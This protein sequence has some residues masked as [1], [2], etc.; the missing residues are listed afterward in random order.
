[1]PIHAPAP[2]ILV[3]D[4]YRDAREMYSQYLASAGFRVAEAKNGLEA[5][6][7]ATSYRPDVVLL[8][9]YL[10]GLDGWEVARHLKADRRTRAAIIVAFTAHSSP[11]A[12]RRAREAGC[13]AFVMKPCLGDALASEIR[14]LLEA[15]AKA[16]GALGSQSTAPAPRALAA[17][18]RRRSPLSPSSDGNPPQSD[19][20][21]S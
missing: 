13:A 10:P 12:A 14:R 6:E 1:M 5:I 16:A 15:D 2:L 8:D 17:D 11:D 20:E 9:L 19:V 21:S 4:D 7:K 18:K 3:V